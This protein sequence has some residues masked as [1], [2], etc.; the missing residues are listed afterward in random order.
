MM[1]TVIT[2]NMV[3]E[4]YGA[5]EKEGFMKSLVRTTPVRQ[6]TQSSNLY[7]QST[8]NT[9]VLLHA[10]KYASTTLYYQVLLQHYSLV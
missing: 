7:L 1:A 6:C 10:A 2:E 9:P 5:F 4:N 8:I 3:G